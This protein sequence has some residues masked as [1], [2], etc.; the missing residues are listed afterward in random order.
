MNNDQERQEHVV[1]LVGQINHVLS[2]EHMADG[3]T[4]LTLAVVC[5]I[6]ACGGDHTMMVKMARGFAR[7]L[8]EF[9]RREDIVEWIEHSI[10]SFPTTGRKQ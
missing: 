1:G 10:T 2:G 4:A 6:V 3:Q 7:Q 5:Q 8:E 9:V